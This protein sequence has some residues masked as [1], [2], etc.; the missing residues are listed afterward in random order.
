MKNLILIS[1]SLSVLSCNFSSK[2]GTT[3]SETESEKRVVR[4]LSDVE[5][6]K[7][8]VFFGDDFFA[9]Y[10]YSDTYF[11]PVLF[12]LTTVSGKSLT[13][14]YP[15]EPKPGERIDHPHHVGFWLN[16]GDVNGLDFWNNSNAIPDD[17]KDGYGTIYHDSFQIDETNGS[18]HAVSDWKTSD[19]IVLLNE[20]TKYIFSE[21]GQNRIIDRITEL[22][23]I[24][25]VSLADNKE[26]FIG[27]RV[28]RALEHPS[29][30]PEIFTDANGMPSEVKQLNNDG[31]T[32]NYLSSEGLE[33]EAV[34]GTRGRWVSLRGNMEGEDV[35]ITIFD[36]PNNI[37]YPTY[38]HARGYG[39]F[40]ANPLG[41]KIFSKGKEELNL[42]IK[43]GES[44]SISY[45]ILIHNGSEL[46]VDE[47]EKYANF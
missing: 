12:P 21:E 47:I 42:I 2:P 36:H 45:R 16:Y 41:Q 26:G 19:G 13:R 31:V 25:D 14:G 28:N 27:I 37:G 33:G 30:K 6:E 8:A 43:K 20:S 46:K 22:T 39:L 24:K 7:V 15:I 32:G 35:S 40:A 4:F 1:L 23:A 34:W 5:N 10:I 11:K 38:W 3:I 18:L 17:K 9:N 44:I 29:T